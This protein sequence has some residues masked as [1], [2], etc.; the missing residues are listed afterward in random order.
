MNSVQFWRGFLIS[1]EYF[2]C[3]LILFCLLRTMLMLKWGLI[4]Y[5]PTQ[6]LIQSHLAIR[7][8][9]NVLYRTQRTEMSRKSD[10]SPSPRKETSKWQKWNIWSMDW[11][12]TL[13]SYEKWPTVYPHV[14]FL[15]LE[16][17]LYIRKLFNKLTISKNTY[18]F[19]IHPST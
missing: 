16:L 12:S 17:Q 9:L 19:S 14:D 2:S 15:F 5:T 6:I 3:R 8:L 13:L 10:T 1:L 7:A 11:F 18:L 4:Q